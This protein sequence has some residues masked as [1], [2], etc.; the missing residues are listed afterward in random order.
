MGPFEQDNL[1]R[2][3]WAVWLDLL[4]EIWPRV[5]REGDDQYLVRNDGKVLISY[6]HHMFEDGLAIYTNDVPVTN[7][8]LSRLNELGA[9]IELFS[10]N[11]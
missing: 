5:N 2:T 6:D 4:V 7:T 10:K 9:E 11:G 3:R 1:R 8:L